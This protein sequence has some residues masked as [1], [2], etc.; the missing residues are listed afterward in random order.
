MYSP[1]TSEGVIESTHTSTHLL[2]DELWHHS[3]TAR[4]LNHLASKFHTNASKC[5]GLHSSRL[6][7]R[8]MKPSI[9]TE[10]P[11]VQLETNYMNHDESVAPTQTSLTF[12]NGDRLSPSTSIRS[13]ATTLK[14]TDFYTSLGSSFNHLTHT[15]TRNMLT[16]QMH[17]IS[18]RLGSTT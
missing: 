4:I 11:E 13:I 5:T 7:P 8:M 10:S 9:K 18:T 16:T 1:R 15:C 17:P 12:L 2:H 14:C 3:E 6:N